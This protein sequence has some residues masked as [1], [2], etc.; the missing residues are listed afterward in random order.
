M[1]YTNIIRS[2]FQETGSLDLKDASESAA[3]TM[4]GR[5]FQ[6]VGEE[7]RKARP[8]KK[9]CETVRTVEEL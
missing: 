5:E 1:L 7:Q 9:S 2:V 8:K 6:V 3:V 4:F